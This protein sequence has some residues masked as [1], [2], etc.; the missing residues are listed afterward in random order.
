MARSPE[1]GN[2]KPESPRQQMIS[3]RKLLLGAIA[4]LG[5][6]AVATKLSQVPDKPVPIKAPEKKVSPPTPEKNKRT[7][8]KRP[9]TFRGG[10]HAIFREQV[11]TDRPPTFGTAESQAIDADW[12]VF[13]ARPA[14]ISTI[15]EAS[16][17]L[18]D[19]IDND[20]TKPT[21][22]EAIQDE[23]TKAGV[24]TR[25]LYLTVVESGFQDDVIS[26]ANA[27]G[28]FQFMRDTA[29]GEGLFIGTRDNVEV[30]ERLDSIKSAAAC[31]RY[32]KRFHDSFAAKGAPDTDAWELALYSYNGGFSQKYRLEPGRKS[33]PGFHQFME[34]EM[35]NEMEEY[36]HIVRAGDSLSRLAARTER[37]HIYLERRNPGIKWE[38][39]RLGS[40][41]AIPRIDDCGPVHVVKANET[42]QSVSRNWGVKED[43]LIAAN[44]ISGIDWKKLAVG[45]QLAI[46]RESPRYMPFVR[47]LKMRLLRGYIENLD[48]V[49]KFKAITKS[50][51]E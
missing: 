32:L 26:S 44:P 8:E 43:S 31:A 23:F 9:G 3:R 14:G 46:P 15:D 29:V 2:R 35:R 28:A 47:G 12:E 16:D 5:V 50:L 11:Q 38:S 19:R 42:A 17:R 18:G 4:G 27:V 41:V 25:Y 40:S 45:V 34:R 21:Y 33:T 30:D 22:L 10:A 39:L 51:D 6:A 24:P 37:N 13:Y 20:D 1:G 7:L 48:Y 36:V 49:A